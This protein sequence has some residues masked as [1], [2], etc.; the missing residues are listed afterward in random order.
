[1]WIGAV[2]VG[3]ILW[4]AIRIPSLLR[5]FA[6]V[7]GLAGMSASEMNGVITLV[8]IAALVAIIPAAAVT[9]FLFTGALDYGN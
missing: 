8:V 9:I 3:N 5:R 7:Y 4:K 1:M 2:C 6:D